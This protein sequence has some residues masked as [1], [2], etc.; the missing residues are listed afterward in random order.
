MVGMTLGVEASRLGI[1]DVNRPGLL[2]VNRPGLLE[3]NR[4]E[5]LDVNRP[6]LFAVQE[7]SCMDSAGTGEGVGADRP[8]LLP[9]C[10]C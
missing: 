3:V 7:G 2:D 8:W 9:G 6:E 5:L 4:P 1:L 10:G